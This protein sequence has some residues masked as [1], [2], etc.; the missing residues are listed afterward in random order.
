MSRKLRALSFC[1]RCQANNGE[2]CGL[3][4]VTHERQAAL[5]PERY[6]D[7]WLPETQEPLHSIERPSTWLRRERGEE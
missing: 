4:A 6:K 3:C 2:M 5:D 7:M 1:D